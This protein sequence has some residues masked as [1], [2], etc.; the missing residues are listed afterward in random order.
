[1]GPARLVDEH[2]PLVQQRPWREASRVVEW[3]IRSC[4]IWNIIL[5]IL[6]P[7]GGTRIRQAASRLFGF[8]AVARKHLR[9]EIYRELVVFST[10]MAGAKPLS[11]RHRPQ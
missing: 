10:D 5:A 6:T 3:M 7:G 8:G 11:P 1:M 2:A 4:S 9:E